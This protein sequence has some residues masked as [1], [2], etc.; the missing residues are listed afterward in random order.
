MIKNTSFLVILI[1]VGLTSC[2]TKRFADVVPETQGTPLGSVKIG[3]ENAD[4]FVVPSKQTFHGDAEESPAQVVVFKTK[5]R[6][7]SY[8]AAHLAGAPV[9]TVNKVGSTVI[10]GV[11]DIAGVLVTQ[12]FQKQEAQPIDQP[13]STHPSMASIR[14]QEV[15][16]P[17]LSVG[18]QSGS[19]QNPVLH[20]QPLAHARYHAHNPYR[21][22][23]LILHY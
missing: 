13:R 6:H 22:P 8:R 1:S 5:E 7:P 14:Q 10:G 15:V 23:L 9:R 16:S 4:Y 3:K 12:P 21:N 19:Y 17:S 2:S 11:T 18:P 20:R